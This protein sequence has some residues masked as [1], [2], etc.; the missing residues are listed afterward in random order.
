MG[1][2]AVGSVSRTIEDAR[3]EPRFWM[4]AK[5]GAGAVGSLTA[6]CEFWTCSTVT[7]SKKPARSPTVSPKRR[8]PSN[9]SRSTV[10]VPQSA[11]SARPT[12]IAASYDE[13]HGWKFESAAVTIFV[14]YSGKEP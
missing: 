8:R 14:T 10:A 9:T 7:E 1:G 4:M 2:G 13:N 11:E 12:R 6:K 3:D 5:D